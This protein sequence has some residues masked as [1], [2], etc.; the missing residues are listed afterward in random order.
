MTDFI[1]HAN[2]I[3][4]D[5]NKWDADDVENHRQGCEYIKEI[6]YY[7]PYT[8]PEDKEEHELAILEAK[9]CKAIGPM[10]LGMQTAKALDSMA[11]DAN[12][13]FE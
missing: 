13:Y 3:T 10:M 12:I 11:Q 5:C 2:G 1:T 4:V 9:A 8:C 7:D 6:Y